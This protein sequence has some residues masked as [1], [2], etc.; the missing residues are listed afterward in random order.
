MSSTRPL[1][2]LS[3]ECSVVGLHA[4]THSDLTKHGNLR[5]WA[6]RESKAIRRCLSRPHSSSSFAKQSRCLVNGREMLPSYSLATKK[7]QSF[8]EDLQGE[9][10]VV[11][12]PPL[13]DMSRKDI[14]VHCLQRFLRGTESIHEHKATQR[15]PCQPLRCEITDS[16]SWT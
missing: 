9:R 5:E 1:L 11:P 2:R 8:S 14:W 4:P 13:Q 16:L 7:Q 15:D 10:N 12:W 3:T 6:T